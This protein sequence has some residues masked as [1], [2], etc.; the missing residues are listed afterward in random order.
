VTPL[1][2][3]ASAATSDPSYPANG[4]IAGWAAPYYFGKVVYFGYQLH[5]LAR[6]SYYTDAPG[7]ATARGILLESVRWAG[8]RQT[9]SPPSKSPVLGATAWFT[10]GKLYVNQ[11]VSNVGEVQLR[12]YLKVRMYRPDGELAFSGTAKNAP[13]PLPAAATYT[14]KSWQPTIG[15]THARGV[16]R[17]VCTYEYYDWLKGGLVT[18]SRTLSINSNGTSF[19]SQS[20]GTQ[21]YACGN[22]P[23]IGEQI[24]GTDRYSTA[25]ALSKRG[26]PRGIGPSGTVLLAT[27]LNYSAGRRRKCSH[28]SGQ[29]ACADSR[30]VERVG[31]SVF[32]RDVG[33][34]L[35]CRGRG[36]AAGWTCGEVCRG[37]EGFRN[38]FGCSRTAGWG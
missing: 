30:S 37:V 16:W 9:Y 27:A 25:V 10:R 3:Y 11:S 5:D 13:I 15:T 22:Q 2:T 38:D 36:C 21:T 32:R 23:V 17:V 12:G 28:S 6:S 19:T 34:D 1:I 7:Q 20:M 8:M 18:A 29:P 24:A 31:S 4:S 35:G 26:W 14:L 33:D